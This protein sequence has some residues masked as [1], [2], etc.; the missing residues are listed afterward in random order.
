[1]TTPN[2]YLAAMKEARLRG[3]SIDVQTARS[4][5]RALEQYAR[6]LA[7]GIASLPEGEPQLAAQRSV[8]NVLTAARQLE[9]RIT[10]AIEHGVDVTFTDTLNVWQ[11]AS[12]RVASSVGDVPS[13]TLG[14]IRNAEITQAQVFTAGRLSYSWRSLVRDNVNQ[15]AAVTSSLVR[16]ALLRGDSP[17]ELAQ[18]LVPFVT[19]RERFPEG[20]PDA[21]QRPSAADA[22]S[23]NHNAQRI[24][25]SETHNA[26]REA[27]VQHFTADPYIAVGRW[28]LSP[29]RGTQRQPDI[30]DALAGI[31][32]YG[33]GKGVFF[34]SRVPPS[35]HPWDRCE[36][37]P[38]TFTPALRKLLASASGRIEVN[39][40]SCY[41]PGMERLTPN[42]VERIRGGLVSLLDLRP[43]ETKAA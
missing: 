28:T 3:Y 26:R 20:L 2:P 8:E 24:A 6:E 5:R 33:L 31:D 9:A 21:A 12:K 18:S 11:D 25:F 23:L 17:D 4:I 1:M 37:M 39:P 16:D 27:E 36:L 19:G 14:A 40:A 35:P 7:A 34:L 22:Y 38:L 10:V 43:V 13:A 32:W 41:L 42:A 29:N 30:C 15:A